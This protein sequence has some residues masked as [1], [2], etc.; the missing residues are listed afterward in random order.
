MVNKDFFQEAFL[1]LEDVTTV[2]SS[3]SQQTLL[4]QSA[5]KTLVVNKSTTSVKVLTESKKVRRF[6]ILKKKTCNMHK[7]L[8]KMM[9]K[10]LFLVYHTC[11]SY[12]FKIGHY[13]LHFFNEIAFRKET[14]CGLKEALK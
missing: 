11:Y 3:T 2:T 5:D 6:K 8:Y 12:S 7:T 4:M 1:F 9:Q 13:S 14:I 10:R